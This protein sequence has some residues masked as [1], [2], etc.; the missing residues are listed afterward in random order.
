MPEIPSEK[1]GMG[2][3]VL[4]LQEPREWV[5]EDWFDR[6]QRAKSAREQGRRAREGKAPVSPMPS[7]MPLSS[8]P[9]TRP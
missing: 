3:S 4:L 2:A 8:H 9:I 7:T 5:D 6:I 1:N